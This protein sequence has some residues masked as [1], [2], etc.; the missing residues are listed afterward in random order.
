MRTV[1]ADSQLP[2]KYWAEA[3][4]WSTYV[5]NRTPGPSGKTPF[6]LRY[7]KKPK[8]GHLR[9]FGCPCTILM[10]VGDKDKAHATSE[11]GTLVGYGYVTGQKGYR[12]LL[13]KSRKVLTS[14]NVAFIAYDKGILQ[15]ITKHADLKLEVDEVNFEISQEPVVTPNVKDGSTPT[16]IPTGITSTSTQQ[17]GE[18]VQPVQVSS[19]EELP[20]A[21]QVQSSTT[22]TDVL[23][24]KQE[25]FVKYFRGFF[26]F[27]SIFF[28]SLV[29]NAFPTGVVLACAL[30]PDPRFR[31]IKFASAFSASS[32]MIFAVDKSIFRVAIIIVHVE[33]YLAGSA[34]RIH[35]RINC[36]GNRIGGDQFCN[37][38]LNA[39]IRENNA[40]K[41]SFGFNLTPRI[42][43]KRTNK[44][45]EVCRCCFAFTL[46]SSCNPEP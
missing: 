15:R 39:V 10:K 44:D 35:T 5:H 25:V 37:R 28:I 6:E 26:F 43:S 24:N 32:N 22:S 23:T 8:I 1:L 30:V 27:L 13:N 7:N 46:S 38:R 45:I 41:V 19:S 9:P 36:S 20:P 42:L 29:V 2:K 33:A 12:I 11:Y 31:L 16:G 21:N 14:Q 40:A 17:N 34:R 18:S 3:L 4:L